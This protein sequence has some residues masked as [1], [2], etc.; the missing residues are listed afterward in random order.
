MRDGYDGGP[1]RFAWMVDQ[2]HLRPSSVRPAGGEY[3]PW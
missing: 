3:I 2:N 1:G